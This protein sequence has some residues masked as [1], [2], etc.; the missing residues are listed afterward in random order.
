[1]GKGEVKSSYQTKMH[2][3]INLFILEPC[4]ELITKRRMVVLHNARCESIL[5]RTFGSFE[6]TKK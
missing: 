3:I 4:L 5:Q 6:L 1:M 2:A